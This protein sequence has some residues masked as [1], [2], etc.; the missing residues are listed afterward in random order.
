MPTLA[1]QLRNPGITEYRYAVLRHGDWRLQEVADPPADDRVASIERPRPDWYAEYVATTSSSD[2]MVRLDLIA[3][4]E[5]NRR[6]PG[7]VSVA[8]QRRRGPG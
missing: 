6:R 1:P 5:S 2:V 8:R 3:V 7:G 4:D